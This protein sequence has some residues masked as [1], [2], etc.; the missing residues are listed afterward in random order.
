MVAQALLDGEIRLIEGAR[1]IVR[2]CRQLNLEPD[3]DI[4]YFVGIDAE[5]CDHPLGTERLLWNAEALSLIDQEIFE[6]EKRSMDNALLICKRLVERFRGYAS[7][8][9]P[10]TFTT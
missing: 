6:Y 1:R 5:T 4:L 2:L 10:I 8:T 9:S 7:A 3:Q